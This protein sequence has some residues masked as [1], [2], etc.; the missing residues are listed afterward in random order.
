VSALVFS[1]GCSRFLKRRTPFEK[2]TGVQ[3]KQA[4]FFA[5]EQADKAF[6]S[7]KGGYPVYSEN[8]RWVDNDLGAW[9]RGFYPGM[10]WLLYQATRDLHYRNLVTDWMDGLAEMKDDSSSFGLGLVFYPSYVIGYQI[11][12]NRKYRQVALEAAQALSERFN[13]V[14]YFPTWGAPGDTI[15]GRRL[16][17]ETLMDLELLYWASEASGHKQYAIQANRHAFFTLRRLLGPEGRILH[18]ADF[19]PRT[20]QPYGER[21]PELADGKKYATKG[22]SPSSVW[23]LGQAWA[24]YGFTT[25]FHYGGQNYFLDAA[26]LAADYFI[27]HLPEDGMP[28]WDFELPSGETQLKDSSAGA[29]A[30]AALLK[31]ARICPDQVDRQR[32]RKAGLKLVTVLSREYFG[33][34]GP[35]LLTAGVFDKNL[36]LGVG[37]ATSWGDYYFIEAL[38]ILR[39]TKT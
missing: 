32:Y 23:A 3:Y 27:E 2:S 13:P 19:N 24:I 25:A 17:I 39:D 11:T 21:T 4:L 22:Y 9:A 30:A 20:G 38:L 18:M 33:K 7:L 10:L 5:G 35:G 31:L 12:G 37:G 14:G 8:G 28:L 15:L 1:S 16:S 34:Q 29:A 6:I 26:K 36:G